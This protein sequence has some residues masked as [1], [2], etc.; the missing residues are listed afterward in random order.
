[1][2]IQATAIRPTKAVLMWLSCDGDKIQL[3]V[4]GLFEP[5]QVCLC[6]RF[7]DLT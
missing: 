3:K 7:A 2:F 5:M 4:H 1:M 6:M